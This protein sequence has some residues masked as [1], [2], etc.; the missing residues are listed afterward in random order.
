MPTVVNAT[1]FLD[2]T[3]CSQTIVDQPSPAGINN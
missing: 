3:L 2:G 1:N